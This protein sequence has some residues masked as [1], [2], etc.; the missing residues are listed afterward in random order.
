VAAITF[1]SLSE[2]HRAMLRQWLM[3][4]HARAW[5][6]ET[7][8]ELRLIYAVEDGEHEPFIACVDGEPVA[9]VQAWWPT[10]HDNIPWQRGMTSTTRGI[11]I[12]I[13]EARNL[14]KGLGT[15][16]I[17]AFAEKLFMEGTTR[18][19]IDPDASNARAIAAYRKVGFAPF[20]E[21]KEDDGSTTLLMELLP[22]AFD[23]GGKT[24]HD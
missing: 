10:R 4:D 16:I 17:K 18:L 6:G 7:E 13:G 23:Y 14:G 8:E 15:E 5:W 21:F 1:T 2:D 3:S 9:Y 19:I 11:D 20:G 24:K 22:N 12:T